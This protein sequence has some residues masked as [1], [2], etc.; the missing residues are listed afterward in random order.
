MI[1]ETTKRVLSRDS[2][3]ALLGGLLLLLAVHRA[4]LGEES[5]PINPASLSNYTIE[6]VIR[7]NEILEN[8]ETWSDIF[9]GADNMSAC[10]AVSAS[11][12]SVLSLLWKSPKMRQFSIVGMMV[13]VAATLIATVISDVASWMVGYRY[14]FLFI[15]YSF[16]W[17]FS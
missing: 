13:L 3:Q 10:A 16:F 6:D 7:Y 4:N 14:L 5:S 8:K 1:L 9:R 17:L 2:T 15:I 12:L 11:I